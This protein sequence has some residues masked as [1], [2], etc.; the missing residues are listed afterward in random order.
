MKSDALVDFT[1]M[2]LTF[3]DIAAGKPEAAFS[4]DG[5]SL[6][7]VFFG[8]EEKNQRPWILGMGSHPARLSDKGWRMCIIFVI[9]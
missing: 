9:E 7:N 4:Y 8:K 3:T 1:D 6:K 5:F 2:H